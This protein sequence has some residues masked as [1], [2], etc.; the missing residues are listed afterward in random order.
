M[1]T[2]GTKRSREGDD[3]H[4]EA[5][6]AE[7]RSCEGDQALTRNNIPHGEIS[8]FQPY[9][10]KETL[11]H[12][13]RR[14][15]QLNGRRKVIPIPDDPDGRRYLRFYAS[16]RAGLRSFLLAVLSPRVRRS[17]LHK[18]ENSKSNVY[19]LVI[20]V[21]EE[22]PER[23]W[24]RLEYEIWK[25][26]VYCWKFEGRH[27]YNVVVRFWP[28][29]EVAAAAA[30]AVTPDYIKAAMSTQAGVRSYKSP[31][32]VMLAPS[33]GPS[34]TLASA[35]NIY[36]H[37][38]QQQKTGATA[39]S[40]TPP[41]D[42]SIVANASNS[43]RALRSENRLR[44]AVPLFQ[45]T[46][47]IHQHQNTT[48]ASFYDTPGPPSFLGEDISSLFLTNSPRQT[49]LTNDFGW[50]L[51]SISAADSTPYFPGKHFDFDSMDF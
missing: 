45:N 6:R 32:A 23:Y 47:S 36:Y 20:Q 50:S 3:I 46:G 11:T 19:V 9:P 12:Y 40:A 42:S 18:L 27:D 7:K 33:A 22:G 38:Q 8:P 41:S 17:S 1:S 49:D 37:Q 13:H 14:M 24:E 28:F 51:T 26:F 34:N 15:C 29:D 2:Q 48:A 30:A 10:H 43:P 21:N 35:P 16:C 25:R 4:E 39:T 5:S 44:H 31:T